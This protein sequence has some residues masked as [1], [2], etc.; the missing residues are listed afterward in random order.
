MQQRDKI[1]KNGKKELKTRVDSNQFKISF[2]EL[3]RALT[4]DF[5][6]I[7]VKMRMIKEIAPESKV[8]QILISRLIDMSPEQMHPYKTGETLGRYPNPLA[9][10]VSECS[11]THPR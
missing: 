7:M 9:E 6:N 1:V 5:L 2:K 10:L 11:V 4:Q 8:H 3:S